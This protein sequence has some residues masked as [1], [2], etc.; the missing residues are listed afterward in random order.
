MT[1]KQR[2]IRKLLGGPEYERL[3]R[4]IHRRYQFGGP[5]RTVTLKNLTRKEREGVADLFGW[6]ALPGDKVKI[7]ISK[8]DVSLRDTRMEAGV[9][10]VVEALYG[11]LGLKD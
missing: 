11:P 3:F 4:K 6:R 7:N 2:Q 1:D 5:V 10:E 9:V 8:L